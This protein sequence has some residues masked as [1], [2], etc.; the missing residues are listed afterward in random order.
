MTPM[1]ADRYSWEVD[2]W[3]EQVFDLN[4]KLEAIRESTRVSYGQAGANRCMA[5]S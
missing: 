5:C 3:R 4:A 2:E 1:V